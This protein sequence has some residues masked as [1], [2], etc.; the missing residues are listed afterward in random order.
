MAVNQLKAGAVLNYVILGLNALVG[1]AYTPYMLRTLGQSEYGIYSLAAAIIAYLS[2]LDLGF[3]NAVIRYTSKFRAEGKTDEQYSMFGLFTMLYSAIAVIVLIAGIILYFSLDSMFGDTLT[4]TELQ[5]TKV[6]TLLMVFNLAVTFPLSIYGAIIT[7]YEDFIFL[8]VVQI[9]KILLNTAV[10]IALLAMGYK[11]IAMVVVHTVFNLV[12][13]GL[14]FFYCRKKIR[15]KI[16]FSRP[17][18][19]FLKEIGIYSFWIFLNAIMDRIYWSTGQFVLGATSGTVAISV[20][21]VAIQLQS[22]YMLFSGGI[23]GVFLPRITSMVAKN[24]SAKE[25]S[26]VF[27]KVGRIQYFILSLILAGF[28]V[29]GQQFIRIWAGPGYEDSYIITL[30]F[31]ATLTIPLIQNMGIIILQARNQMKFRSLLYIVI[32][33]VSLACQIPLAKAYGGIGCAISIGGALLLGQ[34]LII[35]IYYQKVQKIDIKRFWIEILRMSIVPI[36][37]TVVALLI[38]RY[39]NLGNIESLV[40]A[41]FAFSALYIPLFCRFSMNDYERNLFVSPF[42]KLFRINR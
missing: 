9:V 33:F 12:T 41:I 24:R 13:L 18:I 27:I 11:A 23:S 29:F 28:I 20:F 10:M 36:L 38:T 14:N 32:S 22:M 37:L 31:F 21:A 19:P 7:A 6:I 39:I 26:D 34:G 25:I 3:G 4:A 5:R 40:I 35:N 30:I 8:R 17:N 15:I 42:L 2:M 1:L 16:H